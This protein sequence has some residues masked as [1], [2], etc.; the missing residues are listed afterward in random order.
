MAPADYSSLA[1]AEQSG[2]PL[3]RGTAGVDYVFRRYETDRL[4]TRF[5]DIH[6]R[7]EQSIMRKSIATPTAP[8]FGPVVVSR[9]RNGMGLVAARNFRP[10]QTIVKIPG[11]VVDA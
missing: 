2:R 3:R 10:A 5:S 4:K 11:R 8:S 1:S 6:A 7:H 9:V